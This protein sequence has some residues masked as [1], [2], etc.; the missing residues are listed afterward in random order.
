MPQPIPCL[1]TPPGFP[2]LP[3]RAPQVSA[4]WRRYLGILL[5][6]I[7]GWRVA[8]TMPE[9]PK[10][11]M[12]VAPHTSNWDFF[13]GF[14]AYLT[15]QLD[16]TWLAKHTVFFWPMGILAR[17]FGGMPIDRSRGANVVRTFIDEFA[18][19]ERMSITITPEGTRGRVP[20]W[21]L[22]FL[23]IASEANVPVVPV[24]LDYSRKLV[25]IMPAVTTSGDSAVDLPKIKALYSP[26]MAR[27]PENF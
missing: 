20:E 27:Y 5:M 13:H 12:I 3:P 9:V 7:S 1:D 16:T 25:V 6:K 8:G 18:R 15:L 14:T 24:A 19:R 26:V 2:H 10:F 23:R 17:R 21:K 22:G 11:V 4:R